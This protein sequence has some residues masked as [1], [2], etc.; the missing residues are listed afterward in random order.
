[1]RRLLVLSLVILASLLLWQR[2]DAAP[3]IIWVN[4]DA[5]GYT[6]PGTSCSNA[7]YATIQA[8]VDAASAGDI[9]NVCPGTYTENVTIDKADLTVDSTNGASVT[10]ITAAVSYYV[11][12]I[13]QPNVTL[14]G[15]TIV[16]SGSGDPDLG[17]FVAIEGNASAEITHNVITG[18]RIGINLGCASSGSTIDHNIVSGASEAGINVDTC[19]A[20]RS[21]AATTIRC[22][23]ILFAVVFSRIRLL[24]VDHP[25][26]TMSITTRPSGLQLVAPATM[27][28]TTLRNFSTSSL[29]TRLTTIP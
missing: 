25:T 3:T 20:P 18:G 12:F 29:A 4:D 23:T 9:I 8:A 26:T 14:D 28:T 19:E 13:T 10:T 15:F 5:S 22:T 17:V 11:V 2:A 21:P 24:W 7:G 6:P 1:M 16:P 27:C